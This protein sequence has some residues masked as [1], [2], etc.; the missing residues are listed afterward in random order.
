MIFQKIRQAYLQQFFF[1][2]QIHKSR[3]AEIQVQTQ[4]AHQIKRKYLT[5][6]LPVNDRCTRSQPGSKHREQHQLAGQMSQPVHGESA[7][8]NFSHEPVH[9]YRNI[10]HSIIEF[11]TVSEFHLALLQKTV[12]RGRHIFR[13][14]DQRIQK[15]SCNKPA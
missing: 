6:R 5:N 11:I 2:F 9:K 3:N 8:L 1:P 10:G 15:N 7:D 12:L 14:P 13:L 4:K